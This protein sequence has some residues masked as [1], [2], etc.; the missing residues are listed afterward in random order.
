[1]LNI[2]CEEHLAKVR[3]FAK[4]RGI[5]EKLQQRLDYLDTYAEGDERGLTRC[6][7]YADGDYSFYF[8]ML[9]R[10]PD[11]L[12]PGS[13]A[14][15]FNGGMIYYGPGDTGV[16]APQYSVRLGATDEDWTINT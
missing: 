12:M 2:K 5:E 7:L 14:Y 16:G 3:E 13:Y 10:Q 1:M 11:G 4:I 9:K 8:R 15:W 6:D